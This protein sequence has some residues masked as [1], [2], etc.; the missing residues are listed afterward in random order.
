[1]AA[2]K[3]STGHPLLHGRNRVAQ[4]VPIAL[5]LTGKRRARTPLLTEWQIAPQHR[6]TPANKRL[7]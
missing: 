2:K 4:A 5:T 3:D 7:A 6:I 1:M